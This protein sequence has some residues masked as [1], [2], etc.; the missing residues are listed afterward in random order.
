MAVNGNLLIKE[1]T[2]KETLENLIA[3]SVNGCLT[4]PESLA[5]RVANL[6]V[7]A[8]ILIYP[9]DCV[10]LDAVFVPDRFFAVRAREGARYFVGEQV[11]LIRE[12]L[13]R[14]ALTDKGIHFVTP[15]VLLYEDELED[16]LGLFDETVR[17]PCFAVMVM[18][19]G[20]S[21]AS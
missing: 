9:D 4:I 13:D 3:V 8:D 20:N 7:S 12:G 19:T 2:G 17:R 6:S 18:V 11:R 5:N 15:E 16:S 1:E 14:K 21:S 10:V